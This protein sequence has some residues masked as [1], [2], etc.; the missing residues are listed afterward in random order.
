MSPYL[1]RAQ[2]WFAAGVLLTSLVALAV[3]L[4]LPMPADTALLIAINQSWA[5]PWADTFFIWISERKTFTAPLLLLILM[6]LTKNHGLN[7]LKLWG[8]LAVAIALGDQFGAL[9]K[10]LFSQPRPCAVIFDL[11]RQPKNLT[12]GSCGATTTGTPSS[13]ALNFFLTATF[14]GLTLRSLRWF[15]PLLVIAIAVGL[16]RIYLGVHYPSQVVLGGMIGTLLA[17]ALAWLC[18]RYLPF[19]PTM[20]AGGKR[21]TAK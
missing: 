20:Q 4:W 1:Y 17:I 13:H 16:S 6:I 15:T 10:E 21:A 9:L 8:L 5:A 3:A 12:G 14:L 11:I 18:Q 7:G 19:I 2:Y